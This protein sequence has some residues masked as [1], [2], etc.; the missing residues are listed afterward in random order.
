[1]SFIKNKYFP[2]KL[3]LFTCH[4][5]LKYDPVTQAAFIFKVKF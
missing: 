3:K 4:F 5:F 2:D 1:M